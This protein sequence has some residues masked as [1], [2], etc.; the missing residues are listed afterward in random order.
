MSRSMPGLFLF[1]EKYI[2]VFIANDIKFSDAKDPKYE[3]GH[4]E[5]SKSSAPLE[6]LK[7]SII[8]YTRNQ[9]RSDKCYDF[10]VICCVGNMWVVFFVQELDLVQLLAKPEM[11]LVVLVRHKVEQLRFST[12]P[13]YRKEQFSTCPED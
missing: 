11:V 8:S 6:G 12:Q 13:K 7:C 2:N 9:Q 4:E 10:E 5:Q 1:L 3:F